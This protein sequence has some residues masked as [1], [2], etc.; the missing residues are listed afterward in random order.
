MNNKERRLKIFR[1]GSAAITKYTRGDSSLYYCP[2]CGAGYPE[3]AAITGVDLTLEHVPPKS[4]GGKPILLTCR[5]C[6]SSAG[7]KIDV[8][9]ASKRKFEEFERVLCGHEKATI[10]PVTL[11]MANV[12]IVT[13]ICTER[14]FDVMPLP[15]ANAPATMEK[16]KEHL[17]NLTANNTNEFEFKLSMTQKYDDRL[18]KLS[19]FKSAF[20]LV[21]AWLGYRYAFDP[22]LEIVRQQIQ[23]PETDILGTRFW[24]QGNENTPLN[25]VMFL[26]QPLPVFLVSFDGFYIILPSL[27]SPTDIYNSLSNHWKKGQRITLE[28][29]VLLGS[30]PNKLQMKL[31]NFK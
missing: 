13:S 18:Y 26:R 17:R 23:K 15:N 6:N 24:I 10:V 4:A 20:L 8:C 2:I 16:Y 30:W 12:D 11:S 7:H 14:C 28:A 21:F 31:D 5:Q 1:C 29:K 27:E 25:K 3:S 22:C 19:Q 9:A